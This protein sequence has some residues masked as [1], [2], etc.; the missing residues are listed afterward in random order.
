MIV[1]FDLP[2]SNN[3]ESP[4][5]KTSVTVVYIGFLQTCLWGIVLT[6]LIVVEDSAYC[7]WHHF[8]E[9]GSFPNYTKCKAEKWMH[10]FI[11]ICYW[12]WGQELSPILLWRPHNNGLQAAVQT[13]LLYITFARIIYHSN[14]TER[15]IILLCIL[16]LRFFLSLWFLLRLGLHK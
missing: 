5:K 6:E 9:I 11:S 14:R 2:T 4:E 1:S 3:P 8:L 7:E 12:L 16:C 10:P 15:R 13:F